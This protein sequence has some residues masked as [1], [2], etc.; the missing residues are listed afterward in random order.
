VTPPAVGRGGVPEEIAFKT[1]PEVAIE[2]IRAA[3]AAGVH[4]CLLQ[5]PQRSAYSRHGA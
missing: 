4:R 3:C 2:Q 5:H 1:K